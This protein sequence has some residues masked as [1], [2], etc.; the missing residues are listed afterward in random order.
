MYAPSLSGV[1]RQLQRVAVAL[2]I[3]GSI[4]RV[5]TAGPVAAGNFFNVVAMPD[6]SVVAWGVNGSGQLGTGN[7]Q[8]K[9]VPTVVPGLTGVVA[10]SAGFSHA[11]ALTSGGLVYTWGANSSKQL[12]NGTTNPSSSPI[13]LGLTG[14]VA[15]A[16]GDYHS[17]ALTNDGNVWIWGQGQYGQTGMNSTAN[18][19]APTMVAALSNV[20]AIAAGSGHTMVRKSDGTV[21]VFGWNA[22]GQLAQ[23]NT[24][25]NA[26]TPVQVSGVTTATAVAAGSL[27]S[28]ILLAD[29]TVRAAGYN[30]YGQAGDGTT[31]TPRTSL[32]T[33]SGLTSVTAIA[34]GGNHSGAIRSDGTVRLWGLGGN[35]QIGVGGS[36]PGNAL[37][38]TAPLAPSTAVLLSLGPSYSLAVTS[39]GVV[40]SFGSNNSSEL[41]DG[42]TQW[43]STPDTI[44]GTN[45]TWKVGT[46]T[47]NVNAGTYNVEKTV[48]VTEATPGATIHYTLDGNDPTESDPTVASG[49]TVQI[50][51]T[52]TLKARAWNGTMPVSNLAS[53]VYTLTVATP[54]IS[55][56]SSTYTT[57]QTITLSTTSPGA[58][59]RYTLDGSTPT[60]ASPQY[61]APFGVNTQTTVRAIGFRTGW[62]TSAVNT[63]T[64]T[65]N[66]GTLGAPTASPG[67]GSYTSS[68]TVT[69]TAAAGTAIRYTIGTTT[70]A[71]PTTSSTLYTA[72]LVLTTSQILK[73][74]A[75]HPDYVQSPVTTAA[76]TITVA[77]PT[78]TPTAG[79]YAAGTAITIATATPGATIR[80]TTTGLDPTDTDPTIAS[81][82]TIP[83][84]NFTLKAKAMFAN[85][86]TSAVASAAYT[87]TG[88]VTTAAI[89]A[90]DGHVVAVRSDG[91]VFA[92]GDGNNQ[93][94]GD[95]QGVDRANP[96]LVSGLSGITQVSAGGTHTLARRSDGRVLGWGQN[97]GGRLGD[98]ST[99]VRPL[100]V[101]ASGI[102]T[103]T[104]VSAGMDHSLVL[105]ADGTVMAFGDNA[106]GQLGLGD[107]TPRSTPTAIPGLSSVVA[108]AAGN[109]YSLALTAAGT[110]Y[111]FGTNGN[112]QLGLGD[113]TQRTTPTLI[114]SLSGVTAIAA[115]SATSAVL[116]STGAVKTFGFNMSGQLGNNSFSQSTSPVSVTGLTDATAIAVGASHMLAR[117]ADGTLV[118]WGYGP[119]LGAG[120]LGLNPT[121]A[122]SG[123][124]ADEH[125][126][127]QCRQR[128]VVRM[129]R[130]R[131]DVG[132]RVQPRWPAWAT[133]P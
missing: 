43:R 130:S 117:R 35:G 68:A 5:A 71:D 44:S 90:G 119:F 126:R 82:T 79:S 36:N 24:T 107:T 127:H 10:V 105:L 110:V 6:G 48:T 85:A 46:P 89:E 41:G 77:T 56:A 66:F 69:L 103:A 62:T 23:G 124:R 39:T 94:I 12:G 128:V 1:R 97:T 60:A 30:Q 63:G 34:G 11:M 52:R 113:Q 88:S 57:P 72:P 13:L 80:Y 55:P 54:L 74:R 100:P 115:N 129:D 25:P 112:G 109:R 101:F 99:T 22:F 33:V 50:D 73:A 104:A 9:A 58:T 53:A 106:T 4:A 65:F 76:Y 118:A 114:A 121:V 84:G 102:T 49:G 19:G 20:T 32:V 14:V 108:V 131:R 37:T 40:Y 2:L 95:G 120:P 125:C 70:P 91:S 75:F 31:T 111:A 83:V 26:L 98:G 15:I 123:A 18:V 81:G 47:F 61:T 67:A 92:W 96:V 86:T 78:F 133:A 27:H 16:A 122:Y 45:Y 42:T 21:W 59:L 7:T 28:L 3:C 116:L 51:Q 29:G 132:V 87:V 8:P 64:Y 38:A 17:V 93:T